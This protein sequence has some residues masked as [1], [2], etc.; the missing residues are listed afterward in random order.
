MPVRIIFK[1]LKGTDIPVVTI[2]NRISSDFSFVGINDR[3]AMKDAVD[4]IVSHNY[5]LGDIFNS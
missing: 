4:Y 5:K 1:F 2:Y 3:Q